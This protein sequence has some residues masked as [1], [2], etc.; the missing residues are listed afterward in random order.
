MSAKRKFWLAGLVLAGIGV[1]L[2]RVV[3]QRLDQPLPK[4]VMFG[5]GSILA[6]AGLGVIMFGIRKNLK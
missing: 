4:L 3:S 5:L 1:V 6:F 2:A